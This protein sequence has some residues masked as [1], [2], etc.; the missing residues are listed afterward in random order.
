MVERVVADLGRLDV[1]VNNAGLVEPKLFLETTPEEWR[2]QVDVC[3]YGVF[4]ACH[5]AAPKLAAQGAGRIISIVGD[6]A[7][8]GQ[9][10]PRVSAGA[11]GGPP[12]PPTTPPHGTRRA[13]HPPEPAGPR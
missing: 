10:R 11:G 8:G 7:R 5:A 4:N 1:V 6:S 9:P 3:L 13:R 2:R 12:S